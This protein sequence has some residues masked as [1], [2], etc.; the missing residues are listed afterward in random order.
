MNSQAPDPKAS[1]IDQDRLPDLFPTHRHD[2]QFWEH[3][4]RAVATFGFLEEILKYAIF[5]FTLTRPYDSIEEAEAAYKE[6]RPEQVLTSQLYNLAEQYGKAVRENKNST[7]SDIDDLVDKI[8][9][10]ATI[11]NVLCHGSWRS[12]DENGNSLPWF[13]KKGMYIF[14]TSINIEYLRHIQCCVAELA[15]AVINS[16]TQMGWQFPGVAGPGKTI[17]P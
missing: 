13:I 3:L 1:F 9:K 12:P 16:V 6:W 8:K 10:A 11:R 7:E 14:D 15:C 17:W 4:G 5:A 2:A